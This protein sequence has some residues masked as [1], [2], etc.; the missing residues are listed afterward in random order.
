MQEPEIA[1]ARPDP[2]R[3]ATD[4]LLQ[5]VR[6]IVTSEADADAAVQYV[7]AIVALEEGQAYLEAFYDLGAVRRISIRDWSGNPYEVARPA[8]LT[9]ELEALLVAECRHL[10][11]GAAL[12]PMDARLFAHGYYAGFC[13]RCRSR[14]DGGPAC[15]ECFFAGYPINYVERTDNDG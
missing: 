11:S 6:R 12:Q 1:A 8:A 15:R 14:F 5:I 4:R 2:Q 7:S 13:A 9:P 3:R 10:A